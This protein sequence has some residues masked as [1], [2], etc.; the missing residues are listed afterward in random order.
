MGH[1]DTVE[2]G[3]ALILVVSTIL[4]QSKPDLF[5][6]LEVSERNALREASA[7]TVAS[8]LGSIRNLVSELRKGGDE[9]DSELLH[10][11]LATLREAWAAAISSPEDEKTATRDERMDAI[12]S[13]SLRFFVELYAEARTVRR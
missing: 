5:R 11:S 4:D 6:G 8:V 13:E 12:V 2:T 1:M 7:A 10:E 3:R 9:S